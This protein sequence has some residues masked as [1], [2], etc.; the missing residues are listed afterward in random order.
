MNLQFAIGDTL[1]DIRTEK[2][3]TLRQVAYKS[4]VAIGYLS[5]VERGQ[6]SA[7]GEILEA[8]CSGLSISTTELMG[9][10]YEYL[11]EHDAEAQG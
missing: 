10:I 7:S 4:H 9:E 6:K 2:Q 8:I 3:M 1:R 5:E 11:K